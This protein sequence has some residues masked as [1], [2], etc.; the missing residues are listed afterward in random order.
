MPT[1]CD[2]FSGCHATQR[3]ARNQASSQRARVHSTPTSQEASQAAWAMGADVGAEAAPARIS[4]YTQAP[5]SFHHT[6]TSERLAFRGT[7]P[8]LSKIL[9]CPAAHSWCWLQFRQST[10]GARQQPAVDR[11]CVSPARSFP[12]CA[13]G[14]PAVSCFKRASSKAQ[15]SR[16]PGFGKEGARCSH[17]CRCQAADALVEP[18]LAWAECG[19]ERGDERG[20]ERALQRR[21]RPRSRTET[22]IKDWVCGFWR[23]RIGQGWDVGVPD[24]R[25]RSR[26]LRRNRSSANQWRVAGRVGAVKRAPAQTR[27]EIVAAGDFTASCHREAIIQPIAPDFEAGELGRKCGAGPILPRGSRGDSRLERAAVPHPRFLRSR[28]SSSR[29]KQRAPFQRRA[30]SAATQPSFCEEPAWRTVEVSP[31]ERVPPKHGPSELGRARRAARESS[32]E[33]KTGNPSRVGICGQADREVHGVRGCLLSQLCEGV[34]RGLCA[35]F[36]GP[37]CCWRH[38][39]AQQLDLRVCGQSANACGKVVREPR[40]AAGFCAATVADLESYDREPV[41]NA[42]EAGKECARQTPKCK[43]SAT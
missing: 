7:D 31:K 34:S 42:T 2:C 19:H 12:G 16:F 14:S 21:E 35:G 33:A 26:Q 40:C 28:E 6:S 29:R 20:T 24:W 4:Q 15:T 37:R 27:S 39:G 38:C 30:L 25:W 11:A 17:A 3:N 32:E 22:L 18:W 5:A 41:C 10:R 23:R 43:D 1:W 8:F 9:A 13:A 36:C